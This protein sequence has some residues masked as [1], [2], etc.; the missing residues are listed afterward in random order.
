MTSSAVIFDLDDTLLDTS[1]LLDARD[2]RDW[3]DVFAR[4]GEARPFDVPEGDV[5]VVT[6]PQEAKRRGYAIGIY[7]HSP[8]K[9]AT[10]LLRVYG[11][12]PDA[13]ITGSDGYPPKPAPTGLIAIARELGIEPARCAYVGDSVADFAAA[14]AAGMTSVGVDWTQRTPRSWRLGWP[15][16]A[17]D[18]PKR[19][20]QLFDRDAEGLGPLAEVIAADATPD[21]HWGS[22]IRLGGRAFALGRYFTTKDQRSGYHALTG[23][24]LD[25]KSDPAAGA[26]LASAFARLGQSTTIEGPALVVS[27]PPAPEDERDRFN[28]ARVRLADALGADDGGGLLVMNHAVD[29]YKL[30]NHDVRATACADRF[31]ATARLAGE[32]VILLDDVITSGAQSDACRSVLLDAGASRVDVFAAGVSQEPCQLPA[33][34]AVPRNAVRSV[35]RPTATPADDSSGAP[36]G[37]SAGGRRTCRTSRPE[38]TTAADRRPGRQHRALQAATADRTPATTVAP[39][40]L[41]RRAPE[42]GPAT[43]G[44]R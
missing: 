43:P 18:R 28:E 9:Y 2:R 24:I 30:L 17:V 39:E 42:Q 14:A 33:Q 7:T 37:R 19:L 26:R 16:Y 22:L 23:L 25:A 29:G 20:L 12:K 10:E 4:L 21:W 36:G 41:R 34:R 35:P 8:E 32:R 15:D 27:V 38:R 11:I 6:L 44:N 40:H 13:L 5:P 1:M 3:A 31:A